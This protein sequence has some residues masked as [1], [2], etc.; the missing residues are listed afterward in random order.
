MYKWNVLVFIITVSKIIF[1]AF[2]KNVSMSPVSPYLLTDN[3]S[4][5]ELEED[6]QK[7][8]ERKTKQLVKSKRTTRDLCNINGKSEKKRSKRRT[9]LLSKKTKM[10]QTTKTHIV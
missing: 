7:R 5:N 8:K 3:P 1:L 9:R 4:K 6:T 2:Q 10:N